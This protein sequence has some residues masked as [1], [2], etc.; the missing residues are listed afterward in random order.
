[1][2]SIIYGTLIA[3]LLL[4][5][6]SIL[7]AYYSQDFTKSYNFKDSVLSINLELQKNTRS[8][9]VETLNQAKGEI[10]TLTVQNPGPFSKVLTFSNL[11]GCINIKDNLVSS[12]ALREFSFRIEYLQNGNSFGSS[13]SIEVPKD[14]SETFNLL[15]VYSPY[16]VPL[17]YFSS[18]FIDGVSIYDVSPSALNP[19]SQ[20]MDRYSIYNSASN[21]AEIKKSL[22]PIVTIPF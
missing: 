9:G 12:N 19:L 11:I 21:C 10:G 13:G 15:A 3:I 18:E 16:G 2:G 8:D 17:E 6:G 22:K 20:K 7:V 4:I 1:M 5:S 14:S